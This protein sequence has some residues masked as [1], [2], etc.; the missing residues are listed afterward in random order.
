MTFR[1]VYLDHVARISG[2]EIAL[3]RALAALGDRV[4]GHVILGEHGPLVDR[5]RDAGVSVEVV[6]MPEAAREVRRDDVRPSTLGV[7]ALRDTARYVRTLRRR[8]R[9]LR[10][11]LI[12][13]NSLKAALYGGVAGRLAGIP[14]IWHIRDRIAPDYLPKPA[15][16]MVRVASRLLPSVVIANSHATLGTLHKFRRGVVV[17]N[18]VVYDPIRVA[19]PRSLSDE[20][21]F[22]V[23]IVGRLAAW[24]GQDLFLE[25]FARA[26]PDGDTEAWVVGQAMFGEDEWYA[27][28]LPD[29]AEHLGIAERVVFRGF[30]ENVWD[31]L[32][33]IHVLVHCSVIPEPFGQVVV[34]GMAAGVPVI[35]ADS[36]GPAE[37]ITDGVNGLLTAPG[38]VEA[39]AAAMR[40]VH[41]DRALRRRLVSGGLVRAE[42]YSPEQTAKALLAVYESVVAGWRESRQIT[43]LP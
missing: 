19:A 27:D 35:A 8:L 24:K 2:G 37:I 26:L 13:T 16:G 38:D 1:V 30:R 22:R 33:Q 40:K 25:A 29:Q 21:P 12:H 10:P 4:D 23:G 42:D 41:D 7:T 34:E 6:P 32:A 39:L 15:V 43:S 28:T 17:T 11:D 9:E 20:T 36:G 5:L 18:T 31:E 14:V 3:A